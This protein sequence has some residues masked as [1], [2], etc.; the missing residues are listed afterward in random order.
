[1]ARQPGELLECLGGKKK[2]SEA[3]LEFMKYIWSCPDGVSS[4]TIYQHFPQARGTKSTILY[5][6]SEKGYVTKVQ[7]GFHHYY[8]ALVSEREYQQ[9][10]IKQQLKKLFGDSSFESLVA[11]LCGKKSLTEDE[12]A[13]VRKLFE[14]ISER[15]EEK[16]K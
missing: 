16:G 7:R 1:M 9:A 11:A 8:T 2:M 15:P 3:E 5:N 10:L 12:A 13:R 6:I 14:E 4:E